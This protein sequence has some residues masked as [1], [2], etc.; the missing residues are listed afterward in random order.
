MITLDPETGV[1]N[2]AFFKHVQEMH[3]GTAGVY[4][5]VLVEG[6]IHEHDVVEL[7]E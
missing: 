3:D 7:L 2:P 5:A 1:T 4:A 6:M